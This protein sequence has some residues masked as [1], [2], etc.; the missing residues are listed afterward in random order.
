M[1]VFKQHDIMDCGPTCLRMVAK[2]YGKNISL[3]TIREKSYLTKEGVSFVGISNAAEYF[4]LK[5]LGT[6]LSF[7]DLYKKAPLPCIL[8]FDENHFVVLYKVKKSHFYIA[9]PGIGKYILTRNELSEK[10]I[11]NMALLLEVTPDFYNSEDQE[12]P[13][14]NYFFKYFLPHKN[15]ILQMLLALVFSSIVSLITPFITQSVVDIGILGK[16]LSFIYLVLGGQFAITLSSTVVGFIQAWVSLHLSIR[17]SL[18]FLIGYI[19]KLIKMPFVFFETK[20]LGDIFQR[21]GDNS[22]I[23]SFMSNSFFS[24]V[25]SSL[26]LIIYTAIMAYYNYK[27]LLIFVFGNFVYVLWILVFMKKRKEFDHE[28]FKLASENQNSLLQLFTGYRDIKLN[29][30]EKEKRWDW[31]KIQAK[32]FRLDIKTTIWGQLQSSGSVVINS[33]VGIVMSVIMAKE[34]IDGRMTL[35]MMMSVQFI[36]GQI[37]GPLMSFLGLIHSYQDASISLDRLSEV[38]MNKEKDSYPFILKEFKNKDIVFENVSFQHEGILSPKVLSDINFTIPSGKV[39]AIVGQSGSGKATLLKL[40]LKMWNASGGKIKLGNVDT[41]DDYSWRE[42]SGV[43]MQDSFIFSDTILNNITL[44]SYDSIN[45]ERFLQALEIANIREWVES[46]PLSYKTKIGED[47]HGIS[48]GQK[49]RLL[50]ARVVYKNPQLIIFDEAT[51]TL[52]AVNEKKILKNLKNK[53]KNK[54]MVV[55]AHRLSTIRDADQIL[56]LDK[57]EI[58]EQGNHESLIN[59]NG[60]YGNL[61]ENQS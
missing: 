23:E 55:V 37:S 15:L 43:V 47:G 44:K 20:T 32:Q 12:N 28:G 49:Q 10:W 30:L 6:K 59:M 52:D 38:L 17:V 61:I 60:I 48:E 46:L 50:I 39:T 56:V 18:S 2:H 45:F 29:N 27:I 31:E 34:V 14:W 51:N 58:V 7:E 25:I 57:G 19:S 11:S 36:L 24:I 21:I 54:M 9:D 3:T 8:H 4:G 35:G 40:L 22:R 13:K 53:L 5:S 16:N 26:N 42:N 1:K 41:I 33:F